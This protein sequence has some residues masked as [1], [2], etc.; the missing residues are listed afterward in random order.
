[1][2]QVY[3]RMTVERIFL[4]YYD[5]SLLL[6]DLYSEVSVGCGRAES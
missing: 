6:G 2:F 3:K 5:E 1:M 4:M